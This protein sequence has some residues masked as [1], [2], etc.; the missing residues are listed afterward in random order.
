MASE[1]K[2]LDLVDTYT[3]LHIQGGRCHG[4]VSF[5]DTYALVEYYNKNWGDLNTSV[6]YMFR[7]W[8]TWRSDKRS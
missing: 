4:N 7:T 6:E 2:N 5:I 1:E 8:L 3:S